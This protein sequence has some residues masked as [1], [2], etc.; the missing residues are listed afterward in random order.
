MGKKNDALCSYLSAP[1]IFADWINGCCFGGK[2]VIRPEKLEEREQITYMRVTGIRSR[3]AVKAVC[4]GTQYMI[5]GVEGQDRVHPAMPLRCLEYDVCQYVRQL[6]NLSVKNR[7]ED[8]RARQEGN[9]EKQLNPGEYLSGMRMNDK[10]NPVMTIVFYHGK[11]PY[12]GCLNLHDMLDLS[13]ENEKFISYIA[14]YKMNLVTVEEL[15]E[16]NFETGLKELIGIM[17]RR[18]D[19][20]ALERYSREN[21]E[22]MSCLDEETYEII[23]IMSDNKWVMK[24][25]EEYKEKG[26]YNMCKAMRDWEREA[27]ADGIKEGMEKG[28]KKGIK[29]GKRQGKKQGIKQG[30]NE[31]ILNMFRKGKTPEEIAEWTDIPLK[32][33]LTVCGE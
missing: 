26:R 10:L 7:E 11:L 31:I 1:E 24:R 32:R 33:V 28:I 5:I 15:D 4:Q 20:R 6:R 22:R 21:E 19:K 23:S 13:K 2:K 16:N 29:E 3:D 30:H 8:K 12:D 18:Q 27:K 14:D 17:K 25:K 9:K